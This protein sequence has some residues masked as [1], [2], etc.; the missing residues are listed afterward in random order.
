M[1]TCLDGGPEDEERHSR[2]NADG[3]EVQ[4]EVLDKSVAQQDS[5]GKD[6]D[7]RD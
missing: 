2:T 7:Y 4:D 6:G 5:D 1:N 3:K